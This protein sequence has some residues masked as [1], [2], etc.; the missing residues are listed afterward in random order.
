MS[1]FKILACDIKEGIIKNKRFLIVPFLGVLECMYARLN[2]ILY[3][4]YKRKDLISD[5]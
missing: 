4:E 2:I 1:V 5:E 3:K